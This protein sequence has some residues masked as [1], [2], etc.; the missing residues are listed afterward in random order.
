[1]QKKYEKM[2]K[3]A[4]IGLINTRIGQIAMLRLGVARFFAAFDAYI[5]P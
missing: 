2:R 3:G 1:M 4:P 5:S